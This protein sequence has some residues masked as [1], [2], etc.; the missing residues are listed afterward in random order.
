MKKLKLSIL[1]LIVAIGINA[2]D[3]SFKSTSTEC[4]ENSNKEWEYTGTVQ[5]DISIEIYDHVIIE[6]DQHRITKNPISGVLEYIDSNTIQI[7]AH[8]YNDDFYVYRIY[9]DSGSLQKIHLF[10]NDSIRMLAYVYKI[11]K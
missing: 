7:H 5:E 6:Q 8:S 1:I 9:L 3:Y 10:P 4:W 11:D 2:Q